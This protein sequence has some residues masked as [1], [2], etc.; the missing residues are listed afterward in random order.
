M[1]KL[2]LKEKLFVGVAILGATFLIIVLLAKFGTFGALIA[3]ALVVTAVLAVFIFRNPDF[4]WYLIVFFL[5]FERVPSLEIG[6]INIKINTIL[7]FV[8]LLAWILALMFN[9]KKYKVQPYAISVPIILF[10]S[11]MLISLT[12]AYNLSRA[13][14]VLFFIFFTIALSVLTVNMIRS[15]ENLRKT[16]LILFLTS[17]IAGLF[18]LFQFGGNL[19]GLP[20]SITLLK[21]GYGAS[22]FGFPRIQAFSEEPLY[23]ANFLLIPI[24]VGLALFFN[25]INIFVRE[26][27]TGQGRVHW[28]WVGVLILFLLDFVLT[29]S[30]GAYVGLAV[31]F[32]V[33][34]ILLYRKVVTWKN[35]L[36]FIVVIGIV[37]YGVAFALSKG[38]TQATNNFISHVLIQDFYTGESVQGRLVTYKAALDAYHES[39]NFGVGIGNYGPWL[40]HYPSAPPVGGWQ[41]VNNEYLEILA[42]TGLLGLITFTLLIVFLI[43][44]TFLALKY[45]RDPFL[46]A[47]L[48]GLFAAFVGV[49]V[50]Y[51]FFST[52]YI[53]YIW[54]LVGLLTATQTLILKE[55]TN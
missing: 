47:V 42:E 33:L 14:S 25:K 31:A 23:F 28:L 9:A 36:T 35:V 29:V 34:V 26:K 48:I 2:S 17:V 45:A 11:A 39:P 6:G 55:K 38:S 13:Y 27:M 4:G 50:Q 32:I 40:V 53:I 18:G 49:L 3:A 52:L 46:R 19:I 10:C 1:N 44:R 24:F 20:D 5:P 16:L 51:N 54:I 15:K 30:R 43:Y 37:G 12:Q 41:T 7:G 22:T 8:T 21:A